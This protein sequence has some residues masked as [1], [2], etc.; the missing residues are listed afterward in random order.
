MIPTQQL[1]AETKMLYRDYVNFRGPHKLIKGR[2]ALL[3]HALSNPGAA[4]LVAAEEC[5]IILTNPKKMFRGLLTALLSPIRTTI[6]RVRTRNIEEVFENK[7][8]ELY[9]RSKQLRDQILS[10]KLDG[11]K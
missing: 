8:N 7:Y 9:P 6:V 10:K 2:K 3:E 4:K 11:I 1:R 5:G